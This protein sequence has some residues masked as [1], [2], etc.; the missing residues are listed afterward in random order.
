MKKTLT[1]SLISSIMIAAGVFSCNLDN[2]I[3]PIDTEP[4][5]FLVQE[6][7]VPTIVKGN[8]QKVLT[9]QSKKFGVLVTGDTTITQKEIVLNRIPSQKPNLEKIKNKSLGNGKLKM[10]TLG[11]SLSAGV[12]DGGYFNEGIL[13]SF[14]NLIARQMGLDDFALPLFDPQ[15]YNGIGRGVPSTWQNISGGPLTKFVRSKNNLAANEYDPTYGK[16]LDMKEFNREVDHIAIPTH[17]YRDFW[18]SYPTNRFPGNDLFTRVVTKTKDKTGEGVLGLVKQKKFDFFILEMGN[19]E[20]I[21]IILGYGG[22]ATSFSNINLSDEQGEPEKNLWAPEIKL[23]KYGLHPSGAK[24]VLLNL[25]NWLETPYFVEPD[26]IKDVLVK[27]GVSEIEARFYVEDLLFKPTAA[28]DSLLSPKV[29]YLLKP[30]FDRNPN[31]KLD[32]DDYLTKSYHVEWVNRTLEN[33]NSLIDALSKKYGYPVVDINSL[34][35]RVNGGGFV[36]DFGQEINQTNFYSLDKFYPSA[37]GNAVISNEI[38]KVINNHFGI[39]IGLVDTRV[40]S[41]KF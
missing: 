39:Q 11:Q 10:I 4:E 32:T 15:E 35:K 8:Y 9:S 25:P 16:F 13:T 6:D 1:M 33:F 12:R 17:M 40:F 22:V 41:D 24:G 36:D 5:Y 20:V 27:G 37:L 18:S 29:P 2:K 7:S 14:P 30:Y 21:K 38:I 31:N 19:E 28:I 34:Y 23:V 3:L 26:L